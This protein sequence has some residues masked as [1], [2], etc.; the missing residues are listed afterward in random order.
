MSCAVF[1][2]DLSPIALFNQIIASFYINFIPCNYIQKYGL[3]KSERFIKKFKYLFTNYLILTIMLL[4]FAKPIDVISLAKLHYECRAT[5]P[6]GFMF[7][8]GLSFLKTYYK[9][10]IN[11]KHSVII[12]AEDENGYLL[13]FCSGTMTAEAHLKNL[14][15]NRFRIGLSILPAIIK[16][17]GTIKNILDRKKF[18]Y[19]N[20][21]YIK[22]G[23]ISGPRIEYWAWRPNNKSNGAILLFKTWLKVLFDLGVSSIKA[24]IDI[25]NKNLLTIHK[26]LGAKV[27][28]HLN[29]G[30]GRNRVIIEY[31]NNK[32]ENNQVNN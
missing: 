5:Q 14:K 12:V 31:I 22:Y 17:P 18:V 25:D 23:V 9:I 27:V 28:E 7:K 26:Y 11:E 19:L 16:S 6:S 30:D 10:L 15:G 32:I 3:F 8:L 24:E 4:R 2:K 13:G 1:C 20:S 21:G 29:L